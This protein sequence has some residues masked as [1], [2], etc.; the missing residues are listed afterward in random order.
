MYYCFVAYYLTLAQS[1]LSVNI[2]I[3]WATKTFVFLSK[4]PGSVPVSLESTWL[5]LRKK[6]KS[7]HSRRCCI[8]RVDCSGPCWRHH[9]HCPLI[10]WKW[11]W[12]HRIC[13]VP[14]PPQVS[15]VETRCSVKLWG[16][17]LLPH[18]QLSC[19]QVLVV[20]AA[21]LLLEWKGGLYTAWSLPLGGQHSFGDVLWALQRLANSD[22]W[23]FLP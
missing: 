8:N 14:L 20:F 16:A 6:T 3:W 21:C 18:T 1:S 13:H 5:R 19:S 17:C 9:C 23:W 22:L 15:S 12:G 2:E 4:D 7:Q 11:A 10:V